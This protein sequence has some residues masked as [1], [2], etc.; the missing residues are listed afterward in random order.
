[1]EINESERNLQQ[2][3]SDGV[4]TEKSTDARAY[5]TVFNALQKEPGYSL[6]DSFAGRVAALA[7]QSA[8]AKETGKDAWLFALGIV[9]FLGAFVFAL[10]QIDFSKFRFAPGVGVFTFIS[11]NAGLLIFGLVFVIG[12]HFIEKKLLRAPK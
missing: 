2:K 10:T 1:M 7:F 3:I 8:T 5:R 12:L 6:P 4:P 9:A 11:N